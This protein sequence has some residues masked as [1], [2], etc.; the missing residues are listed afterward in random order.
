MQDPSYSI[1][2]TDHMNPPRKEKAARTSCC[3]N[4]LLAGWLPSAKVHHRKRNRRETSSCRYPRDRCTICGCSWICKMFKDRK[5]DAISLVAST[6]CTPLYSSKLFKAIT[7]L[8][9]LVFVVFF[10]V[11][12]LKDM[13]WHLFSWTHTHTLTLRV[14]SLEQG[15]TSSWRVSLCFW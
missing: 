14:W 8:I 5:D 6:S 1:K 12:S 4:T 10:S 3:G 9:L 11:R 2:T 7:A 15:G 13:Q